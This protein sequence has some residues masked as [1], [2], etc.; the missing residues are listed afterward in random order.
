MRIAQVAPLYERVAPKAHGDRERAVSY[1]TEELVAR[2]HEVTLFASGDSETKATL[3]PCAP[4]G[5]RLTGGVTD[6]LAYHYR[7][8]EEV[9]RR[10]RDFDV[11]HLHTDYLHFPLF[12]R[13]SSYHLTTLHGRLDLLETALL[14][15]EFREEP[16]VSISRTQRRPLPGA[17]WIGNV[18]HGLPDDLY[19]LQAKPGSYLAFLGRVSAEEGLDRAIEIARLSGLSLKIM[20]KMGSADHDYYESEIAPL[21]HQPGIEFLGE[22]DEQAKQ[23]LLGGALAL[24]FPIDWAEPFGLAMIEAFACGTPVVAFDRG[25]VNE[26]VDDGTTGLIVRDVEEAL[27]ALEFV[28]SFDRVRIRQ[29]FEDRFS[30]GRMADDYV[31]LYWSLPVEFGNGVFAEAT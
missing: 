27:A 20:A 6:P 11:V 5:L 16:L 13:S 1:L 29:V 12:R 9:I 17:T 22:G 31:G 28:S 19:T 26:V 7:M 30:A 24:L 21:L 25:S 18:Y 23:E 14:L 3:M 2:G 8:L 10:Q 4:H 15:E